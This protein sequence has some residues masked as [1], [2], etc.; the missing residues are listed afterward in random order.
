MA[1]INKI[2][3]DLETYVVAKESSF[4]GTGGGNNL[5]G[6]SGKWYGLSID[7]TSEDAEACFIK[8]YDNIDPVIGTTPPDWVFFAAANAVIHITSQTGFTVT[9]GLSWVALTDAST[10]GTTAPAPTVSSVSISAQSD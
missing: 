10:A 4:G 8:L 6:G 1:L 2:K 9:N 7:N 3:G 5:L